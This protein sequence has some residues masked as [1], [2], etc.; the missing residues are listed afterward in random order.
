MIRPKILN[1]S[2]FVL[3]FIIS[4]CSLKNKNI[5]SIKNIEVI[6]AKGVI[7][8]VTML[9][10]GQIRAFPPGLIIDTLIIDKDFLMTVGTLIKKMEK[11]DNRDNLSDCDVRLDC[12]INY[13]NNKTK[14][15]CIGNFNCI[16][17]NGIYHKDCDTLSYLIK[18]SV[19]YYNYIKKEY[20]INFKEI[21]K[22]GVPED[23]RLIIEEHVPIPKYK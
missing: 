11:K 3:F 18:K 6:Y 14:T 9:K 20:L 19:G 1:I 16:K 7:S 21:Q 10:C 15:I 4:G 22:F 13:W 8:P 2:Y 5:D 12:I 17:L 23:Y